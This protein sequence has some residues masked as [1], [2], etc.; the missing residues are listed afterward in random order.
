MELD[1]DTTTDDERLQMLK[2]LKKSAMR[3]NLKAFEIYRDTMGM[4]PVDNVNVATIDP[5]AIAEV[6]DFLYGTECSEE[7]A[8]GKTEE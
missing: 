7:E 2:A 6:E 4:K 3:G 1:A 5:N 8:A